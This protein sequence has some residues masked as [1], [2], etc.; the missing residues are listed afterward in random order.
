MVLGVSVKG[1]RTMEMSS[2]DLYFFLPAAG[3]RRKN[4]FL[5]G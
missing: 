1:I 3:D 5:I 4:F 2:E